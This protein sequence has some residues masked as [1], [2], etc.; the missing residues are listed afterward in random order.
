MAK[1]GIE[2]R[3]NKRRS[4]TG[5]SWEDFAQALD[6]MVALRRR[7]NRKGAS[8]RAWQTI[9]NRFTPDEI[10][11]IYSKAAIK[12]AATKRENQAKK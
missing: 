7:Q 11:E 8:E 12:A 1:G 2:W 4:G 10:A 3:A 6:E 9:R 5:I